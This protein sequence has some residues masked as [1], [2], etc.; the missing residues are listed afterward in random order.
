MSE[1]LRLFVELARIKSDIKSAMKQAADQA[2][3]IGLE[4]IQNLCPVT[5][6]SILIY[7]CSYVLNSFLYQKRGTLLSGL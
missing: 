3:L 6:L 5:V 4:E 7:V 2:L 1:F